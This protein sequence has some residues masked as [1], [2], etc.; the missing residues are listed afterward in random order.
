MKKQLLNESEIKKMM[1]FANIGALSGNF[2]EK[3]NEIYEQEED[4]AVADDESMEMEPEAGD[5]PEDPMGDMPEDPMGGGGTEG[6]E[7]LQLTA[8]LLDTLRKLMT[9]SGEAGAAAAGNITLT[10]EDSESSVDGEEMPVDDPE[11]EG[12]EEDPMDAMG[13]LPEGM[14]EGED[15]DKIPEGL[16]EINMVEDEKVEEDMVNEVSRRVARRLNRILDSRDYI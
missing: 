5:L 7:A 12:E 15:D 13:E 10:G 3:L 11:G 14:G 1:K 8:D 2:V 16:E 4:E 6:D 9:A